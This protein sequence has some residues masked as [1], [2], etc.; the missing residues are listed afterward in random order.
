MGNFTFMS[1]RGESVID[2][3][4]VAHDNLEAIERFTVENKI[5][6]DHMPIMLT[7]NVKISNIV[8][9]MKLLPKLKWDERKKDEYRERLD[10]NLTSYKEQGN[11]LQLKE[12]T[13]IVH[14]SNP[15][16]YEN[17][18]QFEKENKWFNFKC[19][20][21]R[22]KSFSALQ[23]YRQNPTETNKEKYLLENNKFKLVCEK[24]K[25]EYSESI[26]N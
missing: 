19:F 22:E 11:I 17:G 26:E 8:R 25:S 7:M 5:W 10:R 12:L 14:L 2:I 20:N 24:S 18:F 3:C 6:S 16:C 15:N 4:A 23:L 1:G 21:S 13:D 9:P